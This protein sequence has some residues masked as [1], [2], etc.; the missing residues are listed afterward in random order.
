M[1]DYKLLIERR[2][3]KTKQNIDEVQK[4]IHEN[5]KVKEKIN[6]ERM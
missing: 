3:N 6:S 2:K 5:D 1:S 4:K